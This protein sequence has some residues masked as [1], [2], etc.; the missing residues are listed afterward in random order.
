MRIPRDLGALSSHGRLQS[1]RIRLGGT[2]LDFPIVTSLG[3]GSQNAASK[4]VSYEL[5]GA[6]ADLLNPDTLSLHGCVQTVIKP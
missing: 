2:R 3:G 1:D 6:G 4:I 5:S